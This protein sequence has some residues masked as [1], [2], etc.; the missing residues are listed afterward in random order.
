MHVSDVHSTIAD[1]KWT[2]INTRVTQTSKV[3]HKLSDQ[4]F[5]TTKEQFGVAKVGIKYPCYS[6]IR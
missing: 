2:V 6:S 5:D 3:L 1:S 4:H